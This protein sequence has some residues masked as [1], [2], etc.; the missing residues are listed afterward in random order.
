MQTIRD[1]S[2]FQLYKSMQ[3]GVTAFLN[4]ETN[5]TTNWNTGVYAEQEIEDT[6][7]MTDEEFNDYASTLEYS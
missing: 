2:K 3:M 6:I 1:T 4:K 7:G 5:L